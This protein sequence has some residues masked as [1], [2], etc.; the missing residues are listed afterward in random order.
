MTPVAQKEQ[1]EYIV[2]PRVVWE[3]RVP[4]RVPALRALRAA[5]SRAWRGYGAVEEIRTQRQK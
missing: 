4:Q 2:L 1:V 3:K 5:V